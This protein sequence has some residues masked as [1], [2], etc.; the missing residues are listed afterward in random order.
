MK[1]LVCILTVL[2]LSTTGCA[3]TGTATSS[4]GGVAAARDQHPL[5][6]WVAQQSRAKKRA[7]FGA[8]VG[9]AAGA[10]GARAL[11]KDPWAGAAVGAVAGGLAGFALGRRQDEL[12]AGRDQAIE[13]LGGYDPSQGY[14]F[15]VQTVELQPPN[16]KPG[17]E[18]KLHVR[19]IVLGPDPKESITVQSYTGVKY[20]DQYIMGQDEGTFVV[21]RGGGIV[22]ATSTLT[23]PKDAPTGTYAV[24]ALFEDSAGRFENTGQGPLYVS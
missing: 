20:D 13:A 24:E 15:Q 10:V 4:R 8:L 18:S 12:Y 23:I 1:K 17:E 14:I 22:N 2:A 16:P 21:P 3:T 9:A 5:K 6:S 19:Y 7:I 11:G